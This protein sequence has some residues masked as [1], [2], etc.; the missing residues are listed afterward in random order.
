M[1]KAWSSPF[2]LYPCVS[3]LSTCYCV[4]VAAENQI[5]LPVASFAS[6]FNRVEGPLKVYEWEP[7]SW[8]SSTGYS[9]KWMTTAF[10]P[11]CVAGTSMCGCIPVHA[12]ILKCKGVPILWLRWLTW[13]GVRGRGNYKQG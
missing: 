10:C 13:E 3:H 1:E 9:G 7:S 5:V 4:H 12:A 2:G 11:T 8:R 6:L